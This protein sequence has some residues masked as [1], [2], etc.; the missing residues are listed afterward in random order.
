MRLFYSFCLNDAV[1]GDHRLRETAAG[2]DLSWVHAELAPFYS[3][4]VRPSIDP[5]LMLRM[6]ILG[7]MFAIRSERA[8]CRDVQVNLAYRWFCGLSIEESPITR[9]SRGH[10]TNASATV[11]FSAACFEQVVETC[12]AT[13]WSAP[14]G[15]GSMLQAAPRVNTL[16]RS[17]AQPG[18][19]SA[20]RPKFV[21][22]SDPAAQWTGAMP[23]FLCLFG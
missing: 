20:V 11:T 3:T 22:P 8:L 16:P 5:V 14:K 1:P 4:I 21:S 6:L 10:T 2:P 9:P 23:A 17:I 15:S 19:A 12:I 18:A 13:D 7:Y